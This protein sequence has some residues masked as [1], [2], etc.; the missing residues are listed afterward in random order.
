MGEYGAGSIEAGDP[1]KAER[2]WKESF[3]EGKI[4]H[5]SLKLT[6]FESL[7]AKELP[8]GGGIRQGYEELEEIKPER[9]EEE[10]LGTL[11]KPL[12]ELLGEL[13][14]IKPERVEEEVLGTLEKPLKELLEGAPYGKSKE[15]TKPPG[16]LDVEGFRCKEE[17]SRHL[18]NIHD[19]TSTFKRTGNLKPEEM[20]RL[21]ESEKYAFKRTG[22][23]KP[24]E[25]LRL[26]ES[27]KYA[28]KKKKEDL[29]WEI[30]SEKI[31]KVE[32]EYYKDIL[33]IPEGLKRVLRDKKETLSKEEA[34]KS[35][36]DFMTMAKGLK[37]GE[38]G[39][40]SFVGLIE[41]MLITD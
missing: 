38:G 32:K 13:E 33:P 27:E 39:E 4:Y 17:G 35:L 7:L 11:E 6:E 34:K 36:K 20:L 19:L 1:L 12:K 5:L 30:E 24:E 21:L 9:V 16:K 10:I 31:N 37:L 26:L 41:E 22:N 14:E 40:R 23:L 29:W 2:S 18:R 15:L 25:M 8:K 28:I 3:E